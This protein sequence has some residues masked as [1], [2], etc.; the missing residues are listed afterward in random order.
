MR[1]T[2]SNKILLFLI[3]PGF[4][5]FSLFMYYSIK[6][7]ENIMYSLHQ[8]NYGEQ[9]R[10]YANLANTY[11]TQT[12]NN[13]NYTANILEKFDTLSE[14]VLFSLLLDNIDQAN[15]IFGSTIAFAPYEFKKNQKFYAP[16][17]YKSDKGIKKIIIKT[18]YTAAH[19][20]WYNIPKKIKK[21]YWTEPYYSS[22]IKNLKLVSYSV[23][24]IRNERFIGVSTIDFSL[25]AFNEIFS[26]EFEQISTKFVI[27]SSKGQ[28]ISHPSKEIILERNVF[29]KYKSD[30]NL[31]HRNKL[32]T[33]MILGE[34]GFI[35]QKSSDNKNFW[36]FFAPIPI[37]NWSILVYVYEDQ[38]NGPIRE[39]FFESLLFFIFTV[40]FSLTLLV[41]L[42]RKGIK[43]LRKLQDFSKQ[44]KDGNYKEKIEIN[45]NDEIA[46]LA[47]DLNIMNNKLCEKDL[48]QKKLL[49]EVEERV[50]E[51]QCLYKVSQ[52]TEDTKKSLEH[53]LQN[54]VETIPSGWQYPYETCAKIAFFDLV[55]KTPNYKET[56]WIQKADIIFQNTAIGEIEVLY[57]N[58][59]QIEDIGPFMKEEQNL[60]EAIARSIVN[61]YSRKKNEENLIKYNEQLEQKVEERT[62]ELQNAKKA[63]D[64]I[65]DNSPIPIAITDSVSGI[66]LRANIAMA[67][68][69]KISLEELYKTTTPEWFWNIAER[70]IISNK[71]ENKGKITN[72][73]LEVKRFGNNKKRWVLV[74]IL[75]IKY[76]DKNAHIVE[77]SDVTEIKEANIKIN[78][79]NIEISTRNKY[80]S[81]SINYAK[82]IQ[83]SILPS[84]IYIENVFSEFF[85]IYKPKDIVSGDFY[86][87]NQIGNKKIVALVDCTGH[88]VPGALMSMI[89]NTLLNEIIV[90][91]K[92]IN[93]AE[94]LD[95]LNIRII[96][97][98]N[99]SENK[100]AYDGMDVAI[101]VIDE[102]NK[103]LDYSGAYRTLTYFKDGKCF[104]L[105]G[106]KKSIGE[107]KKEDIK[108]S[109][110]TIMLNESVILYLY[111]DGYVDQ[112]NNQNKKIGS[113]YFKELLIKIN[114][115]NL[116]EQKDVLL[117]ELEIHKGDEV[118]RDDITI[119]GI[120]PIAS[121]NK[122]ET[123]FNYSGSFEHSKIL[124][125]GNII[126]KKAEGL[127]EPKV[128]KLLYFCSNEL[129]QNIEF[130]SAQRNSNEIGIG[131]YSITLLESTNVIIL[132]SENSIEKT[133]IDSIQNR[134]EKYNSLNEDE[135]KAFYK[136]KLKSEPDENSKGAG[137]GLIQIL[138]KT[139]NKIDYILKS[140]NDNL[141]ILQ[142]KIKIDI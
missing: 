119:L 116:S 120:K 16:F 57:L 11:L 132:I 136:E 72:C 91:G 70:E 88:G 77:M 55:F 100:T 2:I 3:M 118:Q 68:F 71:L 22:V 113:K 33:K 52:L 45:T 6:N 10:G 111:S 4:L 38:L 105:K 30:I 44:I 66:I 24:I 115:K 15:I 26:R 90:F 53:V 130:Y 19:F 92:T 62:I 7:T 61:F 49:H 69:H 108:Y 65:I 50:K 73:E 104:E 124:E 140:E 122:N 78:S 106:D 13:A 76:L 29:D 60:I 5:L 141:S 81:D 87:V 59:K 142:I 129:M 48:E 93:P 21:P 56:E 84:Q 126:V 28:F 51:L 134:I 137:I 121:T 101:C 9:V 83:N 41:L 58:K 89:G 54:I 85:L 79:Q 64:K 114:S 67:E 8:E 34:S 47:N 14:D 131:K 27:L 42:A 107:V 35:Q 63:T 82:R 96:E 139:K 20:D 17:V 39:V 37:S 32:G 74:S 123:F 127:F 98:L 94:I 135:L 75:P 125:M 80:I 97:E 99:K 25:E 40:V 103:T 112:N 95:K 117:K 110:K 128:V 133:N 138:R 43:P 1:L 109:T 31:E 36:G 18:D 46:D 23:P 102:K 86:W 12:S